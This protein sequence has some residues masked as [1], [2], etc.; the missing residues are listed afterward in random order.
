MGMDIYGINPK[1]NENS[2]KPDVI[3]YNEANDEE[4]SS[5]FEA[6]NKYEKENPGVYFRA[7]VWSWRPIHMLICTIADSYLKKNG[8][9]LIEDPVLE[10]MGMNNGDGPEEDWI[11]QELATGF[12]IWLEHNASGLE[13]DLGCR[14]EKAASEMGGHSFTKSDDPSTTKSAHSVEDEH[15][16]EFVSF[17]QNCGGFQVC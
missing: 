10:G 15:L 16:K 6:T 4:R 12:N 11:C 8:K 2:V 14:V 9:I 7:N 5:Y 17:L 3:N 13:L 1:I